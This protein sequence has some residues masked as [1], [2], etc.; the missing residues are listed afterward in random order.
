MHRQ[1]D[2]ALE[3]FGVTASQFV[4]LSVLFEQDGIS[5]RELVD[6]ITSDANTIRPVLQALMHKGY[7][8]REPHPTD[9]RAW[10]VKLTEDGHA[11]FVE[12]RSGTNSFR[13]RLVDPSRP[14]SWRDSLTC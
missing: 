6:R 2:L 7:V 8:G 4:V 14:L 11:A 3:P 13:K 12:M 9:G 1:A 10:C 5:Q